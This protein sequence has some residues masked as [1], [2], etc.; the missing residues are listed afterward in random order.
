VNAA[1][2]GADTEKAADPAPDTSELDRLLA[3]LEATPEPAPAPAAVAAEAAAPAP[4]AEDDL[5]AL[6]ASLNV[7]APEPAAD[8]TEPDLDALLASLN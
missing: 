1:P 5:D 8:A 4:A 2:E 6:L 7:A 3:G